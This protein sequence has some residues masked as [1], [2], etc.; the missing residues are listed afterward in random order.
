MIPFFKQCKFFYIDG[1][2]LFCKMRCQVLLDVSQ[3]K[4]IVHLRE[5]MLMGMNAGC[6]N[7]V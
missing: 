7:L 1:P 2:S 5:F 6:P 4:K 3:M